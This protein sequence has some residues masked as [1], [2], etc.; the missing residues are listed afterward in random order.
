MVSIGV[1]QS[2]S[3]YTMYEHRCLEN[4]KKSYKS[5]GNAMTN[6]NTRELLKHQWSLILRGLLTT[7]QIHL[8][9]LWL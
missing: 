9:N 5:S 8:E 4:I 2:L 1:N 3:N 6:K 7:F